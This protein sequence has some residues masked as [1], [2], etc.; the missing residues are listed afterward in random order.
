MRMMLVRMLMHVRVFAATF[1]ARSF[2]A[3]S[4]RALHCGRRVRVPNPSS[5]HSLSA[6]SYLYLRCFPTPRSR[7]AFARHNPPGPAQVSSPGRPG[8]HIPGTSQKVGLAHLRVTSMCP[9]HSSRRRPPAAVLASIVA[10]LT[11][12][13]ATSIATDRRFPHRP[14][15]RPRP[16][17]PTCPCPMLVHFACLW[18]LVLASARTSPPQHVRRDQHQVSTNCIVNIKAPRRRVQPFGAASAIWQRSFQCR[19]KSQEHAKESRQSCCKR[20][21]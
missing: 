10:A 2:R 21:M 3:R 1:V 13:A 11:I 8:E 9:R 18:H 14:M 6:P 17:V 16:S 12:A 7:R 19:E 15:S 4:A 5:C 20:R